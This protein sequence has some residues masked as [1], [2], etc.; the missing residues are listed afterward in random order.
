MRSENK[1]KL[2]NEKLINEINKYINI[3]EQMTKERKEQKRRK[4]F[5]KKGYLELLGCLG[6]INLNI[7][8]NRG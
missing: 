1:L 8:R 3:N 5:K 2:M 4:E 6:F 7:D